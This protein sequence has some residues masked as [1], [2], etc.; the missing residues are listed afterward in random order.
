MLWRSLNIFSQRLIGSLLGK[1]NKTKTFC[2][3]LHPSKSQKLGFGS[4]NFRKQKLLRKNMFNSQEH[5]IFCFSVSTSVLLGM[6]DRNT[7][8]VSLQIY[9]SAYSTYYKHYHHVMFEKHIIHVY[10]SLLKAKR[11]DTSENKQI[12][13]M[14]KLPNHLKRIPNTSLPHLFFSPVNLIQLNPPA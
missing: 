1:K 11:T 12:Q 3:S 9:T 7:M 8:H 5:N 13:T 10:C 2:N 4:T 14:N 6:F